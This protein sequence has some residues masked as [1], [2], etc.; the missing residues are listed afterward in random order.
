MDADGVEQSTETRVHGNQLINQPHEYEKVYS[1]SWRWF[2]FWGIW[3]L[4]CGQSLPRRQPVTI[5][6][7][8]E[9]QIWIIGSPAP[10][11]PAT[12]SL[13]PSNSPFFANRPFCPWTFYH[14]S[15][16]RPSCP[17]VWQRLTGQHDQH[18]DPTRPSSISASNWTKSR[19]S[20]GK[21]V[22]K[23]L[24]YSGGTSPIIGGLASLKVCHH[25]QVY[26]WRQV[27]HHC[28]C[29]SIKWRGCSGQPV[30][31][32]IILH[33]M[34]WKNYLPHL[35]LAT[36]SLQSYPRSTNLING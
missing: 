8:Q 32:R 1:L 7:R 17:L 2:W 20:K 14:P 18:Q 11:S 9:P 22:F 6:L 23:A 34:L 4:F 28:R 24:L 15:I 36:M 30:S 3:L 16:H 27:H 25:P 21:F 33:C 31:S 10:S 13:D 35:W 29:L 19:R 5:S 12:S 26:Y